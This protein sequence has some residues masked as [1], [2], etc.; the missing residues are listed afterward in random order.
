MVF[1]VASTSSFHPGID[2]KLY[3]NYQLVNEG[4]GFDFSTSTFT[5][6]NPG[7]YW[8]HYSVGIDSYG[9]ADSYM[10]GSERF[11]NV[12]RSSSSSYGQDTIARDEIFD[13]RTD[14]SQVKLWSGYPVYSDSYLQTSFSG[15]YLDSLS[16]VYPSPVVF[17]L[18]LSTSMSCPLSTKI[19]FDRIFIDTNYGWISSRRE[20][21]IP[22]SGIYVISL[23]AG[24]MPGNQIGLGLYSWGAVVTSLQIGS[25]NHQYESIGKTVVIEQLQGDPIC[26]TCYYYQYSH[27]YSELH[28]HTLLTG[29]LYRPRNFQ[30]LAWS[31]AIIDSV[32]GPAYPVSFPLELLDVGNGWDRASSRYFVQQGGSYYIHLTAGVNSYQATA[33]ELQVNGNTPVANVYLASNDHNGIK[34]RGRAIILRLNA[35]DVL[36]VNLPSGYYV[37]SNG[38]RIATFSGFRVSA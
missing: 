28:A 9:Q 18:A 23:L 13:L 27:L 14:C 15:F 25:T 11:S 37:Y 29:F 17:S 5:P 33:L 24:S 22:V 38:N 2:K 1:S 35:G 31:V 34:T 4:Y 3:F 36:Q 26:A 6:P 16:D 32:I 10:T 7:Y 21:V 20:Y 8:L 19:P 12:I 30:G